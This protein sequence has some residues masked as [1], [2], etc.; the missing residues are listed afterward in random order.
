MINNTKAP[1]HHLKG[2]Q[3]NVRLTGLVVSRGEV[4]RALPVV[5]VLG[6]GAADD[7]HTTRRLLIHP[8]VAG[9]VYG[10]GLFDG[11]KWTHTEIGSKPRHVCIPFW[12]KQL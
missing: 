12:S 10:D 1:S 3:K 11:K 7:L 9:R 8:T 6:G 2:N 4:L 5:D